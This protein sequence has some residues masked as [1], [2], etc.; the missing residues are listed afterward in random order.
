MLGGMTDLTTVTRSAQARDD[1]RIG[2]RRAG[3]RGSRA[4]RRPA[5]PGVLLAIV[6]TGQFMAVL[7]K[8][9]PSANRA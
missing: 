6:L 5:A 9:F 1:R 8:S 4:P 3:P 2:L 7:D